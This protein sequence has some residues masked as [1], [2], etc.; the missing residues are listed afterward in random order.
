[1]GITIKLTPDDLLQTRFAYNPL[2]ELTVSYKV[3]LNPAMHPYYR[4]WVDEAQRALFG[5]DLPFMD[6]LI[7][8]C[9]PDHKPCSYVPDFLTPTPSMVQ[10]SLDYEIDRVL[11]TPADLVR[12]NVQTLI[13]IVGESEM[14]QQYLA[15]PARIALLSGPGTAPLLAAGPGAALGAFDRHSQRRC[16]ASCPPYGPRWP[17]SHAPRIC[18]RRL[19]YADGVIEVEHRKK[20][21]ITSLRA[22]VSSWSPAFSPVPE[23]TGRSTPPGSRC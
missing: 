5:I 21:M 8:A 2:I 17:G 7:V 9:D 12:R 15:L 4:R 23:S 3:L 10:L 20:P 11:A 1:M 22:P 6:A 19:H 18:I 14:R 16:A 13:D